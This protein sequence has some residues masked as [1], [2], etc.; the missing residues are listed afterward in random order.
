[1]LALGS[2]EYGGRWFASTLLSL[3]LTFFL[4]AL[5]RQ[6]SRRGVAGL[7]VEF[8]RLGAWALL[9]SQVRV[10]LLVFGLAA[11]TA[12]S[13]HAADSAGLTPFE[14]VIRGLHIVAMGVW[15]G[16]I[17]TLLYAW[18]MARRAGE[19][20]GVSLRALMLGFAPFAAVAFA[21]LGLTGLV[22]AGTQVASVT[23]L[24]STS[25]G[26][27]LIAKVAAVGLVGA[28][29][30]RHVLPFW[31]A[32][33][34]GTRGDAGLGV[35]PTL[36]IE[37]AGA[38]AVI[39]LA[40][41]LGSS[42]PARGPQF[43]RPAA[44]SATLMTGQSGGLVASVSIKPNREGTNLVSVRVVDERRPAL[45]P[46]DGVLVLLRRPGA[47]GTET[48]AT[49]RTG[50]LFDAGTVRLATGD[51]AVG[52]V[53]R[54]LGAADTTIDLPWRVNP[55]AIQ[56]APV[57]VSSAPLA[58]ALNLAAALIVAVS[59]LGV[60]FGLVRYRWRLGRARSGRLRATRDEAAR[61]RIQ[62]DELVPTLTSCGGAPGGHNGEPA[63][64]ADRDTPAR[65]SS[66]INV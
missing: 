57:I 2:T 37:G 47:S 7:V 32:V 1:M 33:S 4:S 56:P 45:A 3:A 12:V 29:A 58:P 55:P 23:A 13:G 60:V 53:I 34:P 36:A 16:G 31:R 44:S 40:A 39:L 18:V 5:W 54:R 15:A 35:A 10:I 61:S 41:V 11:V 9:T 26:A 46:I 42:A 62:A 38:V 28:V 48:F 49:T 66:Y 14:V 6:A 51:V 59:A 22:L 30:L 17:V 63:E 20:S 24:L 25:Y 21:A 27:T 52:V 8:Q 19:G 65:R 64:E 50:S 43:D